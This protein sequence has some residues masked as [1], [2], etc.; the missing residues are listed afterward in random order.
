MGATGASREDWCGIIA[1][2]LLVLSAGWG[3]GLMSWAPA[4]GIVWMLAVWLPTTFVLM[5]YVI[6]GEKWM[7]LRR[8]LVKAAQKAFEEHKKNQEMAKGVAD[9]INE[10][11]RK[12]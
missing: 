5:Q 1:L 7:R 2:L 6:A 12:K 4:A 10:Q 11:A 3:N 9:I 8:G